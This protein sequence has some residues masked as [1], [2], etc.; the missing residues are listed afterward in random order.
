VAGREM[1]PDEVEA[2]E[3]VA[4]LL[5]GVATALDVDGAPDMTP[6]FDVALSNGL[7]V[8]LEITSSRDEAVIGL[9]NAALSKTW[10]ADGLAQDW[11]VSIP[12]AT[13]RERRRVDR[14]VKNILP[15]LAVLERNGVDDVLNPSAWPTPTARSELNNAEARTASVAIAKL[16]AVLVRPSGHPDPPRTSRLLF[17]V[18][19]G[20]SPD[21]GAVNDLV[22]AAVQANYRKL[23]VAK[24]DERHFFLWV[25]A[26]MADL[27]FAV[28]Q[29]RLPDTV[30]SIPTGINTVW[31]ANRGVIRLGEVGVQNLWRLDNST[32]WQALNP[33]RNAANDEQGTSPVPNLD[34][35][36]PVTGQ[37]FA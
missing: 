17:T 19:G 9:V 20:V 21:V 8:A 3:V 29:G 5:G 13:G 6:D 31:V 36:S 18:Q 1:R 33:P 12:Q 35:Y 25:H 37:D 7:H 14:L 16:G 26:S 30:P 24:A 23:A 2:A 11:Q 32:G 34:S 27:E 28:F 15:E 22:V 4:R 10:E